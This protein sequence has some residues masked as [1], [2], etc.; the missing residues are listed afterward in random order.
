MTLL[1]A[2][3][4]CLAHLIAVV[5]KTE[6]YYYVRSPARRVIVHPQLSDYL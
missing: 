4:S 5:T 3:T 2:L 6:V 1:L